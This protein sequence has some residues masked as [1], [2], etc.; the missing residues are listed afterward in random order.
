[1]TLFP[2]VNVLMGSNAQGKTN[3]L[4]AIGYCSTGRS[5]R[6]SYD[7]E[8][9]QIGQSDAFIK[10]EYETSRPG[11]KSRTD[12]IEMHLRRSGAKYRLPSTGLPAQKI[13]ELFGCIQTVLF[14][15]E[16]SVADQRGNRPKG[17]ALW[18]MEICQVDKVYLHYTPA[19]SDF[20]AAA[21]SAFK[22]RWCEKERRRSW[23]VS[24]MSSSRSMPAG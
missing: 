11:G 19:I 8:C 18:D 9:I 4:E 10:I 14:S 16:G 13:N 21:Q 12:T 3:L 5:H 1:M 6:T 15:P 23:S 20:A 2:G 7:R 17:G 22:G 24:M